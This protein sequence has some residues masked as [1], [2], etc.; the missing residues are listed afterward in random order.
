MELTNIEKEELKYLLEIAIE[1]TKDSFR[2]ENS[3]RTSLNVDE[4]SIKY[5]TI[6]CK[7]SLRLL[8]IYRNIY[9][10]IGS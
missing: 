2:L 8:Q 4:E 10:K 6:A 1:D 5:H 3:I 7:K 9:H